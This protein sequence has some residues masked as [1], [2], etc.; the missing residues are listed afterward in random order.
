MSDSIHAV[1]EL[2]QSI[3]LVIYGYQGKKK[4]T[5]VLRDRFRA[6][7]FTPPPE[8]EPARTSVI[9]LMVDNKIWQTFQ[10]SCVELGITPEDC[11]DAFFRFCVQPE[12]YAAVRELLCS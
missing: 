10:S 3:L 5:F 9:E 4:P 1:L 12:S 7:S 6:E 11:A 2:S 8:P